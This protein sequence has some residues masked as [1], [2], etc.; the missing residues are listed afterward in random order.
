MSRVYD[1]DRSLRE[2]L[3]EG[4]NILADNVVSTLGPR[5]KNVIIHQKGNTP[6]IT[7]DGIT[8]AKF[9]ELDDPFEN[10]AA[11]I[12][13][14]AASQ[15]N[16][17]AGDGTTTATA[18][19]RTIFTESQKYLAA[20]IA[21][22]ELKRGIDSAT[23]KL[24][25]ELDEL[26]RP[27]MSVDDICRIATISA[28]GDETVGK[29]VATAVDKVGKDGAISIEDAR[30]L[31]THL[32]IEEGF[33]FDS[34][35]IAPTFVTEERRGTMRYEE[36]YVLVTEEAI[37]SVDQILAILEV[38]A[39]EGK[40]LVIVAENVEGQALAALIMNT[41]RGSMKVAAVK[42]PR[43]GEERRS[44][45]SDLALVT[46][47][48]FISRQGGVALEQAKLQHLGSAKVVE[49]SKYYTTIV[50]GKGN[51]ENV[52]K[53]IES[54]REQFEKTDSLTECEKLQERTTRLASGVAVIHVGGAT[55]VEMIEKKHRIEDALEAVKSAQV[56]GVVP[57]GGVALVKAAQNLISEADATNAQKIGMEI[58]KHAAKEPLRQMA[59]NAD[60]SPDMI[61]A[62]VEKNE[63]DWGY[64]FSADKFDSMF[65]AGIL[66]PTKVTKNAF[67]N[68]A[69]AAGTLITANNA[70]IED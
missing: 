53:K 48:T 27:I 24:M 1:G 70:I 20:G 51:Y 9:V 41:A 65:A 12:I 61:L 46:G 17:N 43:Y 50:G 36:S 6:F 58:V 44:I 35:I 67:K 63:G 22:A 14:Q 57:G 55:E 40:P 47:A 25:S 5:G 15:T 45:L 30:S 21:P 29:L 7:K 28:N 39:R 33:R 23:T 13:K 8:V 59:K 66:D 68:A 19:A 60:K 49:S 34:G 64:D 26:S 32:D 11:Q 56:S 62:E 2:K 52:E 37:D 38:V 31:E 69:S 42:A 18:L 16:I 3:L 54:L 10:V 4:I